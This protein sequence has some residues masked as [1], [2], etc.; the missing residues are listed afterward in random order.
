MNGQASPDMFAAS[1]TE[2]LEMSEKNVKV[3]ADMYWGD[4]SEEINRY[5]K[6]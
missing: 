3:S 5:L 2:P 1:P 6:S 4:G